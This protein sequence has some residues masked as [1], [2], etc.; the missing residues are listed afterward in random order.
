MGSQA[1]SRNRLNNP[2]QPCFHVHSLSSNLDCGLGERWL[3]DPCWWTHFS[4][5]FRVHLGRDQSSV[6]EMEDWKRGST[7]KTWQRKGMNYQPGLTSG[8]TRFPL[9]FHPM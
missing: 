7:A 3:K 1:R 2:L 9:P 6:E 8:Y 5:T 4:F